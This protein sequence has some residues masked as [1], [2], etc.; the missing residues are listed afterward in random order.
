MICQ[1]YNENVADSYLKNT[2]TAKNAKAA[3]SDMYC[4]KVHR[5][6]L[7]PS[8]SMLSKWYSLSIMIGLL[9]AALVE[10]FV[11]GWSDRHVNYICDRIN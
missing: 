2:E 8:N 7:K 9:A 10:L 6:W 3:A 11:H 1:L 5:R 4:G